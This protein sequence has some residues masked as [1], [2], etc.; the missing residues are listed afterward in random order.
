MPKDSYERRSYNK[1]VEAFFG[2]AK[3]GMRNGKGKK[4]GGGK[5]RVTTKAT[6]RRCQ[7][8]IKRSGPPDQRCFCPGILEERKDE[9]E[10]GGR[11]ERKEKVI[12]VGQE[13]QGE[14]VA[15][16]LHPITTMGIFGDKQLPSPTSF[17]QREFTGR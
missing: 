7:K 4:K 2:S 9:E 13:S 8:T 1:P 16:S 12:K 10:E 3:K 6:K 5:V 14:N 15:T 17:S 11:V